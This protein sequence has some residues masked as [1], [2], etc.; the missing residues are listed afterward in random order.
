MNNVFLGPPPLRIS[1][2][3]RHKVRDSKLPAGA[4]TEVIKA[5]EKG[6]IKDGKLNGIKF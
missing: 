3:I 5:L 1:Q 2:H 6:N 4:W